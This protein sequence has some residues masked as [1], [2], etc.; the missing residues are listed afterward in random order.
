MM[1]NCLTEKP[2]TYDA[3][4]AAADIVHVNVPNIP[5]LQGVSGNNVYAVP[6]AEL[7]LT[8]EHAVVQFPREN[9]Q[10]VDVLGE[11]QFGE[12]RNMRDWK[13]FKY[14]G[15]SVTDHLYTNEQWF[16]WTLGRFNCIAMVYYVMK[17][18]FLC[19]VGKT[20]N[21][22]FFF[23]LCNLLVSIEW[24]VWFCRYTFVRQWMWMG[25]LVTTTS[26]TEPAHTLPK[27]WWQSRC[28]DGMLMTEQGT[29]VIPVSLNKSV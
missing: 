20:I 25:T 1:N 29:C 21:Q 5:N 15:G 23:A 4:Y 8:L 17:L 19:S 6:N 18:E 10:F 14:Y 13:F 27:S 9:L 28:Y 3:L 26:W 16:A 22:N 7:L 12:V 2:P 11:G 24:T